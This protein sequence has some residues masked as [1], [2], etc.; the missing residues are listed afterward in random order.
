Q[1]GETHVATFLYRLCRFSYR[2]RKIVGAIWLALVVLFGVGASALSGPTQDSFEIPGTESQ[3]AFDLL[4]EGFPAANA[5]A[6]S[7]GVVLGVGPAALSRPTQ[8]A[9]EIRGTES[10]AASGLLEDRFRAANAEATSARV[11]V[12]ALRARAKPIRAITPRSATSWP[13]CPPLHKWPR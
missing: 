1:N 10:Q 9:C 5:E 2:R 8:E 4:E 12:A 7:A 3:E 11:V 13:N 6:T